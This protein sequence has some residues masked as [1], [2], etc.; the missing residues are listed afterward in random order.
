M[1]K[2]YKSIWNAVTRSWTAVSEWQS[3]HRKSIKNYASVFSVTL[4]FFNSAYAYGVFLPGKDLVLKSPIALGS[5]DAPGHYSGLTDVHDGGHSIV[6][7]TRDTNL[8]EI[9]GSVGLFNLSSSGF[10]QRLTE[11]DNLANLGDADSFN[12]WNTHISDASTEDNGS[13][14]QN[15]IGESGEVIA[16]LT[17]AIGDAA[18]Q[19]MDQNQENFG[20]TEGVNQN[21]E[22][23]IVVV[24]SDGV[25]RVFGHTGISY[26]GRG[27]ILY[28][29]DDGHWTLAVLKQ[30]NIQSNQRLELSNNETQKWSAIVSGEGDVV[31]SG[32]GTLNIDSSIDYLNGAEYIDNN[33]YTGETIVNGLTL[34]LRKNKSLGNTSSLT[35]ENDAQVIAH[36]NTEQVD[37]LQL[38]KGILSIQGNEKKKFEVGSGGA[39]IATTGHINGQNVT[40]DVTNGDLVVHSQNAELLNSK[41][42]AENITVNY[43]DAFGEKTSSTAHNKYEFDGVQGEQPGSKSTQ[44]N[45]IDAGQIIIRNG[46]NVKYDQSAHIHTTGG[47]FIHEASQLEVTG[48]EQLGGAVKFEQGGDDL[49]RY[50]KLTINYT[51]QDKN[52]DGTWTF[53]GVQFKSNDPNAVVVAKGIGSGY[54]N[55]RFTISNPENWNGYTGWLRISNT[56]FYLNTSLARSVFEPGNGSVGL[57]VGS[58]GHVCVTD[59]VVKID[60][61]GWS[62]D[63][64]NNGVLDLTGIKA[65]GNSTDPILTV[66]TLRMEGSGTIRINPTEY[67]AA[68]SALTGGSVLDYQNGSDRFWIVK[69][70]EVIGGAIGSV[71]LDKTTGVASQTSQELHNSLGKLAAYGIWDYR[72]DLVTDADEEQKGVYLTYALTELQLAGGNNTNNALEIHLD[73]SSAN[74]LRIKVSNSNTNSGGIIRIETT[75]QGNKAIAL[76][77]TENSFTGLVQAGEGVQLTAKGGALGQGGVALYL[78]KGAT[79]AFYE[80]AQ[81]G[82]TEDS[83]QLNGLFLGEGSK[84]TLGKN[85]TLELALNS[86]YLGKTNQPVTTP[87][88]GTDQL[89]GVGNLTLTEGTIS[90]TDTSNLFKNYSGDLTVLNTDGKNAVM[91]FSDADNESFKLQELHGNGTAL[92]TGHVL[93]GDL[94][95]YSGDLK[96]KEG[97]QV[98]FD[99]DTQLHADSSNVLSVDTEYENTSVMFSNFNS[100]PEFIDN[101]L[102][103]GEKINKFSFNQTDGVFLSAN[104]LKLTLE[105]S[106]IIRAD[107]DQLDISAD[108]DANSSLTYQF[109][110]GVSEKGTKEVSLAGMSGDGS[111]GLEF[112]SETVLSVQDTTNFTGQLRFENAKFEVGTQHKGDDNNTLTEKNALYVDTGSTLV[113]N[114]NQTFGQDLTLG[115]GSVIDFTRDNGF[116]ESGYSVNVLDMNNN[117][118]HLENAPENSVIVNVDPSVEISQADISGTLM[119][120]VRDRGD[121]KI[122]LIL[123][124]NVSASMEELEDIAGSLTLQSHFPNTALITYFENETAI[125]DITTGVGTTYKQKGDDL[126]YLGLSYGKVTKVSIYGNQVADFQTTGDDVISAQ[127]V[128]RDDTPG[129]VHFFGDGSIKLTNVNNSYSGATIIDGGVRVTANYGTLGQTSS[130]RLGSESSTGELTITGSQKTTASIDV[131][132]GSKLSLI[133]KETTLNASALN[134]NGEIVLED[135][136]EL[137]FVSNSDNSLNLS[138]TTRDESFLV[139][140]GQG[141]L[142]FEKKLSGLNLSL[143]QGALALDNGDSLGLFNVTNGTQVDVNG[144]VNIGTLMGTGSTFNMTVAF[145][146]GS[147]EE[148]VDGK[149]G[150]HI[151]NGTGDHF[152]NVTSKDLNKGAEESIKVVHMDSGNATFTLSGGKEAITSGG[153]DYLLKSQA[154]ADGGTDYFLSSITGDQPIDPDDPDVEDPDTPVDPD[155]PDETIRNTTV[156]AGSYIGIAY[157]AQLFDL[158]LHD[159]VG[160]RDWINPITG[161]KQTTSLWMHHTMSHERY[162]DSTAQLRMRTTSNTTMLGGDLVQFTTGD[163]GLAY[164]G[165]M[166]GYGTMDT[167]SRSKVTNLHSK[168]ETDA[169]GVGAYAGWKANSDGQTGPY[170][171]GWVMFTHA[172]SD[173]TGVDQNPEDVKGQ[174]LSASL[175]AGWGFKVGSVAT[176]NGKVANFT[177]EPHAS[178]T[179]FGMQYDEIHND[180]QDVKFEGENNVRTRLGARAILTQEG[181]NNFNAFVEANWVHNTQEYG[182][183]I[184][185]LTVDQAGSRNQGEGRIGV[186]WRVTDSFSVW[187]RVGASFG[188]DNYNEREGSIGVRYQF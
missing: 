68:G 62:N 73:Q 145:G 185:G 119:N 36:T 161:E 86:E 112:D 159:R 111:L 183:T 63:E 92:L 51:D 17:F 20:V 30:V 50:N 90:F 76:T 5:N 81:Q 167:K 165:L 98:V 123:I 109:N 108:I 176:K 181:N 11:F 153:F 169:W 53:G 173:V 137:H 143:M 154:V 4:L 142:D 124:D 186:D 146:E 55:P 171:D 67:L 89:K 157:A 74:E 166:G 34:N 71:T 120:A 147:Q 106:N 180:A 172:N 116:V 144:L 135:S 24:G 110:E 79:F 117:K 149:P 41:V 170:V 113:M 95:D 115:G 13:V 60:R 132:T 126:G 33:T 57:S 45:A 1:N 16:Q 163:S 10:V 127:L 21:N 100:G 179:W 131:A 35:I 38:N 93:I 78:D 65:S 19:I 8:D 150:L 47:T 134:G 107:R 70:E 139:K 188:S 25:A 91:D 66:G 23:G 2:V 177:V 52:M 128:D 184:S 40:F 88:I 140:E 77:N 22:S 114:G 28:D 182:A 64:N 151:G 118:I 178:V 101:R 83:Q 105:G 72:T 9:G 82:S 121:Q 26:E 7:S 37:K 129:S 96:L 162:R 85:K 164:A 168:A 97:T 15:L 61:F 122:D 158:S 99:A 43:T 155:H 103:F 148:L 31:Y 141:R 75:E 6:F 160:N 39:V 187:G 125:A 3:T 58:G 14:S 138:F 130:I 54:S 49:N 94:S 29:Y 133:G 69:A 48:I 156:T 104:N 87:E 42:E 12:S 80:D 56:D 84:V 152:L 46:S 174:G 18:Y 32:S 136:S 102:S 175:E 44:Y 27:S 59:R